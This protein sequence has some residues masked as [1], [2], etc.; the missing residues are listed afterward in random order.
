MLEA[1]RPNL[2]WTP[3]AAHCLDLVLEDIGKLEPVKTAM[4][5]YIFMNCY[6]YC[7]VSLVNMMRRFIDQHN[8]HRPAVT[9]F[10]T[11][12]I[13][14]SQFHLQQSNLKKMVTSEEWNKSKWP[15]EAGAKKLKQYILQESF[16]RNVT[17]AL[18]LASPLVKVLRMVDGDK[19]PA[20]GYIYAAMDRAKEAIA[21]SFKMKVE[22]YENVFE[23]IDIRWNCQLH[24]PLHA[25]YFLNPA[26]HY[27]NPEDVCCEEVETGLYNCI[28]RLV[29]DIEVQD[30][31]MLELDLFKKAS[32]LFGHTMAIRQRE[33]KAPGKECPTLSF[34]ILALN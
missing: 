8:L 6:I 13:T 14:M 29:P 25:G 16:W 27:A 9:R 15:K 31:V 5:K 12:F 2:Y 11:S 7:R 17:Y 3:C 33:M 24:Q 30:K 21:S 22:K 34:V 10:A 28:N 23:I 20:M 4:K 18:K 1:K 26:I 32:G 19:K